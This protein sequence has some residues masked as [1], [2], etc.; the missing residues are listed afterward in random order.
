MFVCWFSFCFDFV[1]HKFSEEL[2][3]PFDTNDA[4]PTKIQNYSS[5]SGVVQFKRFEHQDQN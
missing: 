3:S 1:Y 2:W 5:E 4:E